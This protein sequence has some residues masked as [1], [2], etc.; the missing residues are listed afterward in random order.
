MKNVQTHD[1]IV[2]GASTGGVEALTLL[3]RQLPA[4]LAA[5]VLVVLHVSSQH[6]SYLPEIL[7]R[8]GPLKAHHPRDGEALEKGRI[9]VAPND[10]H[11]LLE[12]GRVR[13]MKGPRENGHRPA[14]DPLFRS[15]ASA[16]GPRVVGVV[17]TGALD[18]GTAGLLTVKKEGGVAV[19]QDPRDALCPDM[20]RSALEF[21]AVDHCVP[22]G[23]MTSLL[24]RLVSQPVKSRPRKR[25][26]QVETE[27]TAMTVDIPLMEEPP[28]LTEFA[29]PSHFSCPDCGGVLFEL[30]EEG[31]MRFRC[32]TGHGYTGEALSG[33]QQHRLDAALWA[34]LRAL[35]ESA[36]LA[37]RMAAR[38]KERNHIHSAERF[39]ERALAAEAQVELLRRAVLSGPDP[40]AMP[41]E[42]EASDGSEQTG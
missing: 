29:K 11:L 21:V 32:R 26:R 23:E 22:M 4:D 6:R 10:R 39:D 28:A 25:S 30:D 15:A 13:V 35:E 9:Y 42:D 17:L 31:F 3:A 14:V 34:A 7:T 37:R 41:G 1:I 38:A 33:S 40:S 8:S 36:A 5:T 19:V 18:C 12:P 20:P 27:V 2:I 16:Y 24:T